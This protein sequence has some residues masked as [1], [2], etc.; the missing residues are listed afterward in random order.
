[1][2]ATQTALLLPVHD[3]RHAVGGDAP[4]EGLAGRGAQQA[5]EVTEHAATS[6]A[7]ARAA[8][9]SAVIAAADQPDVVTDA[10]CAALA[11]PR[12]S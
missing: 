11:V 12:V 6:A 3:L 2:S 1:M 7:A 9:R 4:D 10:I 5:T 8:A